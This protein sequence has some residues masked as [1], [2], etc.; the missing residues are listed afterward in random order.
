MQGLLLPLAPL[1]QPPTSRPLPADLHDVA[2]AEQ[3][4]AVDLVVEGAELGRRRPLCA[5]LLDRHFV[6]PVLS[7]LLVCMEAP[8]RVSL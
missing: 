4:K 7:A 5:D 8:R 6:H 3:A 1:S 2:V